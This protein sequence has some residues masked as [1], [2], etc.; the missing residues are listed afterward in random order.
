MGV[1]PFLQSWSSAKQWS[2]R[3][4]TDAYLAA[5]AISAGLR[6]VTFDRDFEKFEGLSLLLLKS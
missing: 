2:P 5:F 3:Y 6:M 4:W 1:E